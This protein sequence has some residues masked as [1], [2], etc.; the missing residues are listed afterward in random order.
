MGGKSSKE[1]SNTKTSK[2]GSTN[3]LTNS[4][5]P[6]KPDVT[7]SSPSGSPVPANPPVVPI[8]TSSSSTST[9]KGSGSVVP[10]T[11]PEIDPPRAGRDTDKTD[12][13]HKKSTA[14]SP[15]GKSDVN[16]AAFSQKRLEDLFQ[17][18]KEA[19]DDQIG[20]D[21]MTQF[22]QDLEVDPADVIMLVIAYHLNAQRMGYFTKDEFLKGFAKMSVDSVGK[23]KAQFT[24]LREELNDYAKFKEI[25][26]FAFNFGKEPDQKILDLQMGISLLELVMGDKP[27]AKTFVKFLSEQTSYKAL[28]LDQWLNFLDF[29]KT[30]KP[31]FS[32]YDENSAWPVILDEY[33][34]WCGKKK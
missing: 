13:K 7:P 10:Q 30:I 22:C 21:G 11:P 4:S 12:K 20:P 29:S 19:E 33:A 9:K 27:H 2:G 17:K 25:Y 23:L 16:D 26:R 28:N 8:Q 32:N 34:T 3:S 24:Q 5:S 31:D 1:R 6:K 15:K 14:T 18:Y